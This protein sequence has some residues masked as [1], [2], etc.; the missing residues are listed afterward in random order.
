MFCEHS[1]PLEKYIE[2]IKDSN[3]VN[4]K[5]VCPECSKVVDEYDANEDGHP[6]L[7]D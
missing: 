5:W 1:F 2:P 3:L 6:L 4:I 7:L